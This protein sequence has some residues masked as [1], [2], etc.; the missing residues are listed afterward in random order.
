MGITNLNAYE[1]IFDFLTVP[2]STLHDL[3][4]DRV[5][6]GRARNGFENTEPAT[7]FTLVDDIR[8]LAG[9]GINTVL[10]RFKS[11]GG[12]ATPGDAYANF[13]LLADRLENNRAEVVGNV[14]ILWAQRVTAQ[15]PLYDPGLD[16]PYL[17]LAALGKYIPRYR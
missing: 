11:W 15:F 6:G 12:S 3:Q 2:G 8:D 17:H 4:G 13:L 9:R 5:W 10:A 16:W 7:T 14:A 1:A